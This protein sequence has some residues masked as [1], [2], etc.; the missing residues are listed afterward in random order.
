MR[1]II[2]VARS[3]LVMA[4]FLLAGCATT[5]MQGG[6]AG[7]YS[8][9][10]E[11]LAGTAHFRVHFGPADEDIV[12]P[13]LDALLTAAPRV[14]VWGAFERPIEIRI[15]PTHEEL[16]IAVG[17]RNYPWLRAWAR[18][19]EILLRS[20]RTFD[21]FERGSANLIELFTHELTHC[22]MY[23][24]SAPKE[25]WQAVDRTIPIWFREGMAS[26]TARQ[27][28]RRLSEARLAEW[29]ERTSRDPLGEAKALYQGDPSIAYAAAH[30][31]FAF[32]VERYGAQRIR[33]LMDTM[34]E[35]R[36]FGEAFTLIIGME[37]KVFEQEY[38]RYLDWGG[39][40]ER[41]RPEAKDV[42]VMLR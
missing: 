4:S 34:R 27:G 11:I 3:I 23:Q 17:R 10:H 26:Y 32:L 12:E 8:K 29:R 24:R 1:V 9:T 15:Y 38:L 42:L 37:P 19:D 40:I 39:W 20:P 21:L 41:N 28:H 6:G 7:G 13:V 30:W 18:Y 36:S 5:P 31:A 16:E 33:D 25:L 22:L 2:T 14:A 35:G